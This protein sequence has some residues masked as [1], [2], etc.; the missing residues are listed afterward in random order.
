MMLNSQ[1]KFDWFSLIIGILWIILGA[2]AINSP[3]TAINVIAVFVGI[4]ALA[5]GIYTIWLRRGIKFLTGSDSR[6]PLLI[7]SSVVDIILGV[8]F[9]FQIHL[10]FGII[11]Y[12]F[13][14]WFIFDSIL[15]LMI[16]HFFKAINRSYFDILIVL[17]I[18]TLILGIVLLF[19]P[20]LSIYTLIGVVAFYLF[21]IGITKIIQAF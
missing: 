12:L 11:A 9:L 1:R 21:L 10:G 8:I 13:A 6:M 17:N 14:F 2:A 16:D 3:S 15:Q 18:I 4:G 20:M 19:N 5:K 7:I